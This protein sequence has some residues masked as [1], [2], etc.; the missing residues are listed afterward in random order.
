MRVTSPSHLKTP[1]ATHMSSIEK[2]AVIDEFERLRRAGVF[3]P[4]HR[5]GLLHGRMSGVEKAAALRAF[6]R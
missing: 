5:V 4:A 2:R 6:S 3:G 1:Y